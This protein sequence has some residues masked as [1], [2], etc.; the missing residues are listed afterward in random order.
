MLLKTV[1]YLLCISKGFYIH[2]L[3]EPSNVIETQY[4]QM[5]GNNTIRYSNKRDHRIQNRCKTKLTSQQTPRQR[6][7]LSNHEYYDK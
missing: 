4:Q 5:I 7:I 1:Y 6:I 3:V 2:A